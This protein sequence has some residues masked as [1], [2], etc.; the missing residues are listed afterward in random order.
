QTARPP[1]GPH[2]KYTRGAPRASYAD[3]AA[4]ARERISGGVTPCMLEIVAAGAA[5]FGIALG[6]DRLERMARYVELLLA[7]NQQLNL[8][9]IVD[10][11]EIERRHLLDSLTCALPVLGEIATVRCIDVGSG[12]GLPGIPL[13]IA[14]PG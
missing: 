10:P 2:T 9:R 11:A 8:T 7:R 5:R 3:A 4:T 14:F 6:A 1:S 13:A 12:G